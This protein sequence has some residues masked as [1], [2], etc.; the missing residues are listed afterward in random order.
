MFW[1]K[2]PE[3]PPKKAWFKSAPIIAPILA[4]VV[5]SLI[6][7]VYNSIAEELKQKVDNKTLQ[8]M[9]EKDRDQLSA[10]E[11]SNKETQQVLK[12]N[13]EAIRKLLIESQVQKALKDAA[14]KA[15]PASESFVPKTAETKPEVYITKEIFEFYMNLP[16]DQKRSFRNLHPEYQALP[17]P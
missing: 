16:D 8:L 11:E 13:Q 1:R 12:Q 9:I 14:P 6:G 3:P 17:P 15:E 10:L 2:K 5:F 7:I 4:A